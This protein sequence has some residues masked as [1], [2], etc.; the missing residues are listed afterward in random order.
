M[1]KHLDGTL[2]P[3]RRFGSED[4]ERMEPDR[5]NAP[6]RSSQGAPGLVPK[7]WLKRPRCRK[8]GRPLPE[9]RP[10]HGELPSLADAR[11][12]REREAFKTWAEISTQ[13][14]TQLVAQTQWDLPGTKEYAP[15]DPYWLVCIPDGA[16]PAVVLRAPSEPVA[17][18]RYN[19]LCG[20]ISSTMAHQVSPYTPPAE[21][22]DDA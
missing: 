11:E 6:R 9:E 18:A 16:C 5:E 21:E 10:S 22:S 14:K 13:E 3:A 15:A 7:S 19:L 20:I 8:S 4:A 1:T 2:E 17:I 12:T